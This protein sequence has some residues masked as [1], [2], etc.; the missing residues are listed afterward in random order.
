M[1]KNETVEITID[2]G[3][4][5]IV[6]L[7]SIGHVYEDGHRWV[8]YEL[9]GQPRKVYVKDEHVKVSDAVLQKADLSNDLTS[10]RKCLEQFQV[11]VSKGDEVKQGDALIITEAMKMETTIQHHLMERF[12]TSMF[13][14]R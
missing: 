4:I 8:Y 7:L 14:R 9:N 13:F 5:L 6:K 11:K 12:L 10:V 2:K 1:A 3:K